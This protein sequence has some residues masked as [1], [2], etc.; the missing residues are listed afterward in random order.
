MALATCEAGATEEPL[1][2]RLSDAHWRDVLRARG[3]LVGRAQTPAKLIVFFDPN[4]P[5][6]ARLWSTPLP[7]DLGGK[8]SNHP[9]LWVPV[10]YLKPSSF[11]RAVAILR[12][13]NAKALSRNF[14]EGLHSTA[15][16]SW[17]DRIDPLLSEKMT[18][19]INHKIWKDI[20]QASPLLIWHMRSAQMPARWMGLPSPKKLEGFLRDITV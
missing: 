20:A 9:A 6:C 14:E 7:P 3:I 4:C 18:L 8:M 11:Q 17:T 19:E 2:V 1:P 16:E 15:T 13:G 12:G 10:A 5:F